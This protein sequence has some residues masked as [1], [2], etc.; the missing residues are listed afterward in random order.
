MEL[1]ITDRAQQHAVPCLFIVNN[2]VLCNFHNKIPVMKKS[3]NYC[4]IYT[5]NVCF[6]Q[7]SSTTSCADFVQVI[8]DMYMKNR[9]FS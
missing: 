8:Q 1:S 4:S 5:T 7:S 9:L 2:F 6:C 3:C